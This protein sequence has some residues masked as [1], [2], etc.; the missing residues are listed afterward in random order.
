[1]QDYHS[2]TYQP[3]GESETS[4]SQAYKIARQRVKAKLAFYGHLTTYILVIALLCGIY[5][6]TSL[7]AGHFYYF[8]PIFPAT[9][10]GTGLAIQAVFTFAAPRYSVNYHEMIEAEMRRMNTGRF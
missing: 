10:W 2:Y 9:G 7:A 5:L 8:W 4:N 1:M 6:M 3:S